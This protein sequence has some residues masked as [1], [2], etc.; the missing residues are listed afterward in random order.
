MCSVLTCIAGR[1]TSLCDV[2][3][4]GILMW[5]VF[6]GG[7]TPYTNMKNQ[8]ARDR[9]DQGTPQS[10][11]RLVI[12]RSYEFSYLPRYSGYRMPSPDECPNAVYSLMRDCWEEKPEKRPHFNRIVIELKDILKMARWL[13]TQ[14]SSPSLSYLSSEIQTNSSWLLLKSSC[15]LLHRQYFHSCCFFDVIIWSLLLLCIIIL[16]YYYRRIQIWCH[17]FY[18]FTYFMKHCTLHVNYSGIEQ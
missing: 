2:W 12:H 8:E 5:E 13:P 11:L 16:Y 7:K 18:Y 9:V 4:F 6:S 15:K 10:N 1:Y 3:S 14:D 17:S